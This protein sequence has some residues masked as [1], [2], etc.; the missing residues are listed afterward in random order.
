[1]NLIL[2]SKVKLKDIFWDH[3]N[4]CLIYKED[5][6]LCDIKLYNKLYLVEDNIKVKLINNIIEAHF[7]VIKLKTLL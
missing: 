7:N 6:K 2:L 3:K 5:K 1:M 4:D